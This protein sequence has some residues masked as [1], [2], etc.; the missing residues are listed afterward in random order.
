[1][2]IDTAARCMEALGNPKRLEIVLLL[3]KAGPEGLPVG[4]I[5]RHLEI[6]GSTLSHHLL[7]LVGA[8]VIRQ[9]REGRVLRCHPDFDQLR[10]LATMLFAECC[11][12]VAAEA[13]QAQ[14]G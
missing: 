9:D 3:V 8:G 10:G 14:A 1:M 13:S 6:P 7:H 11:T 12:G 2:D 5:R 4:D